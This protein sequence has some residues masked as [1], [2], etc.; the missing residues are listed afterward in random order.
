MTIALQIAFLK[1]FVDIRVT[2]DVIRSE[3]PVPV[4]IDGVEIPMRLGR[5]ARV[6]GFADIIRIGIRKCEK[7]CS[8]RQWS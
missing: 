4:S 2:L 3:I 1:I 6:V 7:H 8:A 5:A